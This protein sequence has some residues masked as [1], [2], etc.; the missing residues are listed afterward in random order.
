MRLALFL[1]KIGIFCSE[2]NNLNGQPLFATAGAVADPVNGQLPFIALLTNNRGEHL[3]TGSLISE[4]H[5]LTAA[6]CL[7]K[8]SPTSNTKVVL[9][10]LDH[11]SPAHNK[12]DIQSTLTYKTWCMLHPASCFYEKFT[13][14]I[15]I[16]LLKTKNAKIRPT[17]IKDSKFEP[18]LKLRVIGWG[19]N[20]D[21]VPPQKPRKAVMTVLSKQECE[22]RVKNLVHPCFSD[23][24]LP[25]KVSCAVSDPPILV[26]EGDTG[27]PA[28]LKSDKHISG[29]VIQRC[30]VYGPHDV[31]PQQVNLILRL[32]DFYTFIFDVMKHDQYFMIS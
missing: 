19:E 8:I 30:P 24:V 4:K 16:I 28:F 5:V 3:C 27:G 32:S 17:M 11:W 6:S 12:F 7:N 2:F 21:R 14:D 31:N 29:I 10:T 22:Q 26:A 20:G 25:D 23:V 15:G 13:D 9:G 1:L 18:G